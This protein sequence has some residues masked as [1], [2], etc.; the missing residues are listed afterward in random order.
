M[1]ATPFRARTEAREVLD[2]IT[3]EHAAEILSDCP[4]GLTGGALRAYVGAV[5]DRLTVHGGMWVARQLGVRNPAAMR[6]R[7]E[8]QI[9]RVLG[10]CDT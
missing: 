6:L 7:L 10:P 1:R 2:P 5:L 9:A 3:P 4:P 8:R